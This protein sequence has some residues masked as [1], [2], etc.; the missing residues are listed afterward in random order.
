MYGGEQRPA[1]VG[2]VGA[3]FADE[4]WDAYFPADE[5]PGTP[6]GWSKSG[7]IY[8]QPVQGRYWMYFGDTHIWAASSADLRTWEI[9]ARP[10]ISP[11]KGYFDARL[12]EPGPAPVLLPE[13]L[14]LGYNSADENLRYAFGQVLIDPADPRKVMR[15]SETPL[16]E[17]T[18]PDEQVGQVP[19]V[20]FAEGLA[21]LG[22]RWF[23]YYGMADSRL[24]VAIAEHP[25]L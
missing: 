21:Q 24:G 17:P 13:G 10:V 2:E 25:T 20:V 23:L 8:D 22:G 12:V 7:A 1:L 4:Q 9:E 5:Y 16:L 11:R 18:R 15:R 3:G 14:W 19:Q 6:R